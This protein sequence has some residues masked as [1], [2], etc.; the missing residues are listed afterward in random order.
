MN[1]AVIAIAVGIVT[2]LVQEV[3][4]KRVE[5]E[6]DKAEEDLEKAK[7]EFKA[8]AS[9]LETVKQAKALLEADCKKFETQLG[10]TKAEFEAKAVELADIS[11]R[12][13][14]S[15]SE[16]QKILAEKE[17]FIKGLRAPVIVPKGDRRNSIMLLGLGEVGKTRM[18]ERLFRIPEP[19]AAEKTE[20]YDIY[21]NAFKGGLGDGNN[22]GTHT[23]YYISDYKGQD[24]GTLV[25]AF[26]EQQ[27]TAYSPMAYGHITSVV[28]MLDLFAPPA[29]KGD[30]VPKQERFNQERIDRHIQE[31][32]A[33][34]FQA[35]FGLL[36]N[37]L[38]Y[39]CVFINKIDLLETRSGTAEKDA[40]KKFAEIRERLEFFCHEKSGIELEFIVGSVE[41]GDGLPALDKKLRQ[42]SVIDP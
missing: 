21:F 5:R 4:K 27:F 3:F 20:H 23:W 34:S 11:T 35:V 29:N 26:V 1:E 28:L 16:L 15:K 40:L 9:E 18:I 36:T 10:S 6:K 13:S 25:R 8:T 30:K 33:M 19:Q 7:N 38:K 41:A 31:W 2:W 37:S 17:Y 12:T 42:Y 24:L 32:Q 22:H 39:V 14:T